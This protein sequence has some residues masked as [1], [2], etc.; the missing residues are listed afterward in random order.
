MRDSRRQDD[1]RPARHCPTG[2]RRRC[3]R[4]IRRG[5]AR[6]ERRT[7]VCRGKSAAL[8]SLGCGNARLR[9]GR[10]DRRSAR[11]PRCRPASACRLRKGRPVRKPP[12]WGKHDEDRPRSSPDGRYPAPASLESGPAE[13]CARPFPEAGNRQWHAAAVGGDG[14]LRAPCPARTCSPARGTP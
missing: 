12:L 7:G 5:Q 14:P 9:A 6:R 11:H 1:F 10:T 4:C 13:A 3:R 8:H 2:E